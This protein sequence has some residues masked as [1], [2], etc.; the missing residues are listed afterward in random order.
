MTSNFPTFAKL[1][2]SIRR[3]SWWTWLY[4]GVLW[5]LVYYFVARAGF[6][7]KVTPPPMFAMLGGGGSKLTWDYYFTYQ[8]N[9]IIN[10]FLAF[11]FSVV[12][13]LYVWP[14]LKTGKYVLWVIVTA[15]VT[16]GLLWFSSIN[17]FTILHRGDIFY[18]PSASVLFFYHAVI[19][20]H[21]LLILARIWQQLTTHINN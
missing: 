8:L 17:S 5:F 20:F 3:V 13:T 19:S 7:L 6:P 4:I 2:T 1:L 12:L 18:M 21:A 9:L 16:A 10:T 15:L 14:V 11:L